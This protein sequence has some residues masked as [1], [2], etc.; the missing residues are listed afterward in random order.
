MLAIGLASRRLG[1]ALRAHPAP[2]SDA[3]L[4]TDGLYGLARH[5]IYSGLLLMGV[6]LALIARTPRAIAT[7]CSLAALLTFKARFEERLLE[8]RFPEYRAYRDSTPRFVP[9]FMRRPTTNP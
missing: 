9:R 2:G 1:R 4:R 6:G 7:V 3:T 8:E 5:P